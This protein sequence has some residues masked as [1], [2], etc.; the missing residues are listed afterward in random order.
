VLLG[1]AARQSGEGCGGYIKQ[2]RQSR[3]ADDRLERAGRQT[4]RRMSCAGAPER[5]E[6]RGS[7]AA[8][9]R[10]RSPVDGRALKGR[11]R[12]RGVASRRFAAG[13]CWWRRGE[14]DEVGEQ[15]RKRKAAPI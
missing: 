8:A 15:V 9:A 7:L 6:R 11:R 3:P 13:G 5:V 14:R 2:T 12:A 1:A 10:G 4:D